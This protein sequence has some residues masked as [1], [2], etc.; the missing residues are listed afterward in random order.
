MLITKN[1]FDNSRPSWT[2]NLNKFL[3]NRLVYGLWY[4]I[5][6]LFWGWY[7]NILEWKLSKHI[8]YWSKTVLS[9]AV[10]NHSK[11]SP[12]KLVLSS[13]HNAPE[14]RTEGHKQVYYG[15]FWTYW[16]ILDNF[17]QFWTILD[18]FGHSWHSADGTV[19]LCCTIFCVVVASSDP[20]TTYS[21]LQFG[22]GTVHT[23]RSIYPPVVLCLSSTVHQ[24]TNS[25]SV[26]CANPILSGG[27]CVQL[28]CFD[29]KFDDL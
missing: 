5:L 4:D 29:R 12:P 8:S 18:N 13:H 6:G 17:R 22:P 20:P 19:V 11:F 21:S 16:T 7:Y 26:F 3:P 27:C 28:Q 25:V 14:Y 24:T 23:L 9:F 10:K 15:Q 2:T 1:S